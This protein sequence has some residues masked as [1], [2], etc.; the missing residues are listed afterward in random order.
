MAAPQSV[1]TATHRMS[2]FPP[3]I[4]H[5]TL[6]PRRA[7][8]PR[9]Q[10]GRARRTLRV[11]RAARPRHRVGRERDAPRQHGHQRR[12][13]PVPARAP[14]AHRD[15]AR[16]RRRHPAAGDGHPHAERAGEAARAARRR[17]RDGGFRAHHEDGRHGQRSRAPSPPTAAW[18]WRTC[19]RCTA[20]TSCTSP[21]RC[22]RAAAAHRAPGDTVQMRQFYIDR[23]FDD[24]PLHHGVV[25]LLAG[26][27]AEISH[28]WLSGTGEATFDSA[29]RMLRYSGARTTYKVDV[30]RLAS[31]PT[32]G[33][34]PRS[35]RRSRRRAAAFRQLSVRD[36]V[37]ATHRR[38]GVHRRL[39]PAARARAR[40]ARRRDP[41]RP[42]VAHRA[43]TP[44]RN[45]R[46]RRRSRSPACRCPRARTRCGRSRTRDGRRADREP[47]DRP[48]GHASTMPRTTSAAR[49]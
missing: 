11:R 17:R 6:R 38:R 36:T 14:A 23:E 20:S 15:R 31:R 48:V 9:V 1:V 35:S 5:E 42:R 8:G 12:R 33:P 2:S 7:R 28:D 47:A 45:S 41:V 46:R 13:R 30:R 10:P 27:R 21:P 18:P 43:R 25:R 34:S 19:R 37:R 22:A 40:A 3:S 44:R 4:P 24:F 26:G 39:R 16:P 32:S 29:Y 49:P